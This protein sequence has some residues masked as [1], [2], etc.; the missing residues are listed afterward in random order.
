MFIVLDTREVLEPAGEI[1]HNRLEILNAF[2]ENH[3]HPINVR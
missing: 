3:S 2:D 1:Q